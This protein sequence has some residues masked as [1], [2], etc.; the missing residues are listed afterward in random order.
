MKLDVFISYS[1]Q[2]RDVADKLCHFL[3]D[4]GLSCWI[5]H[6]NI[7]T[8]NY[9]GE[10]TRAVRAADNIVVLCSK[11]AGKSP[12]VKNEVTMA[13]N[14]NKVILPYFLD[15]DYVFD[16]DLEYYL[17]SKQRLSTCGELDKD[18]L[19]IYEVLGYASTKETPGISQPENHRRWV[20]VIIT[21][22]LVL[23]IGFALLYH[24]KRT[25]STFVPRKDDAIPVAMTDT[26]TGTI[27]EG[28]ADGF[29]TY[30]F[31]QRRRIDNHDQ[32]ARMAEQGD[33]I[34]GDWKNGHLNY[35][36]WFDREGRKKGFIQ[37]GDHLDTDLD[38]TLGS[39]IKP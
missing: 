16:D 33:Y 4:R 19:R 23:I 8:G 18:F 39:C 24:L 5:A 3:E 10:I 1:S 21:C 28:L 27:V 2:N 31:S 36:E 9:A 30:T 14:Q 12:H 17:A 25:D 37:L 6:R 32:E 26:F 38:K 35:G 34:I 7:T 11:K 15:D 22:T 20:P 13:F 29:G